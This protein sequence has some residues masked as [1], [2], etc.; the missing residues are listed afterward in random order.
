MRQPDSKLFLTEIV[1]DSEN[2][3]ADLAP[4]VSC[5]VDN[6]TQFFKVHKSLDRNQQIIY[7]RDQLKNIALQIFPHVLS[8]KNPA[9]RE[10]K[11][12]RVFSI[13][14]PETSL[15]LIQHRK[16]KNT[17]IP[18]IDLKF[19]S[20]IPNDNTKLPIIEIIQGPLSNPDLGLKSL[21]MLLKKQ[22]YPNVHIRKS[23]VPVRF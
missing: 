6:I 7:L 9:F 21:D 15:G 1:Y 12:W 2:Q 5:F 17:L 18:Y 13:C 14:H 11:E 10:E 4:I 20:P 23:N 16:A 22:G 8:F 3:L 19:P